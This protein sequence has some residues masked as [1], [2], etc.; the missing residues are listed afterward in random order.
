MADPVTARR[1][2]MLILTSPS[3]AGKSTL[4]RQLLQE[5]TEIALSVSVTTRARR[6]DEI[7]G[8]H[9]HFVD[10]PAFERMREAGDLLEWAEVHGNCYGTPRKAVEDALSAGKDVLF[11]IDVAGVR[12]LAAMVREDMATV[13]LLPPSVAEQIARLKRRASDDDAAIL[14]RLRTARDEIEH[15]ADFDYILVNDDLGRA[16]TELKAILHAERL[17]QRRRPKLEALIAELGRDLDVILG[18]GRLPG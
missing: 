14:K 1:G 18:N 13:F 3:G 4:T 8:V 16:F 7:D 5:E 6:K 2:L 12:Q 10:R 17:K 11:D 15:W 9:Y